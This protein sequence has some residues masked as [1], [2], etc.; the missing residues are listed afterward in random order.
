MSAKTLFIKS[1][2]M[3]FKNYFRGL[4]F[5]GIFLGTNLISVEGSSTDPEGIMVNT[6]KA[7]AFKKFFIIKV[8]S[9]RFDTKS[10]LESCFNLIKSSGLPLI[11]MDPDL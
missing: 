4:L 11:R 5:L 8:N 6:S 10:P 7:E 9:S 3:K 2:K 1:Q